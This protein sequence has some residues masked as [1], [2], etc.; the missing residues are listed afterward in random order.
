MP[1]E[2]DFELW[3]RQIV[4]ELVQQKCG[5]S[6]SV[7]SPGAMLAQLGPTMHKPLQRA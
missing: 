2:F 6:L 7:A 4:R 1:Y 3:T 5:V